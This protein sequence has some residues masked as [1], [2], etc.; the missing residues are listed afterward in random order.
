MLFL[1]AN[2]TIE[3]E[4]IQHKQPVVQR[5][6]ECAKTTNQDLKDL[7]RLNLQNLTI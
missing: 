5:K 6:R 3:K 7:W 1:R 2:V 4:L